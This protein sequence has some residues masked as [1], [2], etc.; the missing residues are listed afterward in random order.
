MMKSILLAVLLVTI[1]SANHFAYIGFFS[2]SNCNGDPYA[3]TPIYPGDAQFCPDT[4]GN[5]CL[6][7]LRGLT[8]S[9]CNNVVQYTNITGGVRRTSGSSS[10]DISFGDCIPNSD[11]GCSIMYTPLADPFE[12]DGT[13][14]VSDTN[15]FVSFLN[16][17]TSDCN[18]HLE[19]RVPIFEGTSELCYE[20][21]GTTC[22]GVLRG[23]TLPNSGSVECPNSVW[24]LD[25]CDVTVVD[26]SRED[27]TFGTCENGSD[28]DF[29][30]CTFT[31]SQGFGLFED[32]DAFSTTSFTSFSTNTSNNDDDDDNNSNSSS[33][34]ALV[35]SS[36]AI[37]ALALI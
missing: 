33:A 18:E 23:F 26:N 29:D 21:A 3:V 35:V 2:S 10:T 34:A 30:G 9:N 14:D 4:S 6:T 24:S 28:Y 15:N 36:I 17:F 11:F 22:T 37:I 31:L 5:S 12:I 32:C 20:S 7:R 19:L 1:V 13:R 8:Q 27:Y 25:D 16:F